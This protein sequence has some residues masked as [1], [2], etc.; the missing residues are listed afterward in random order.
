[1]GESAWLGRFLKV[2]LRVVRIQHLLPLSR[3][4]EYGASFYLQNHAF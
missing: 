3:K 1:M 2:V 4:L